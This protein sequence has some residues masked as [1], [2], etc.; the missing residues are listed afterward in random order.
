MN[1]RTFLSLTLVA[2]ASRRLV[3]L[4]VGP[5]GAGKGTQAKFITDNFRVP[6]IS[7][8]DLLRA[9]VKQATPLGKQIKA[10]MAKGE[11]VSDETVNQLVEI[12]RASCRERV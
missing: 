10:T 5:P 8:G 11:L 7:T 4:L 2:G 1:R 6:A 3:I 9:E 12:G